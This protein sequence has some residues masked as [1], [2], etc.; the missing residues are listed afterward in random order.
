M[1]NKRSKRIQLILQIYPIIY[2]LNLVYPF[3]QLTEF[4]TFIYRML[5]INK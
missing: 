1:K 2:L 4:L 5:S 3:D